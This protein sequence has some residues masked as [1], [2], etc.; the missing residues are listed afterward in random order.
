M[1]DDQRD[2]LRRISTTLHEM[3]EWVEGMSRAS[4]RRLAGMYYTQD[5]FVRVRKRLGLAR[6]WLRMGSA[7]GVTKGGSE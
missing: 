1:L 5:V 7:G 4:N 6:Y 3:A 2:E